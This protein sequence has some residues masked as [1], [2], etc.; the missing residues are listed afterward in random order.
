[1]LRKLNNFI[2]HNSLIG[3]VFFLVTPLRLYPKVMGS[4]LKNDFFRIHSPSS[5]VIGL[6]YRCQCQCVHCSASSYRKNLPDEL[7]Y[8]EIKILLNQIGKLGVPRINF[9]G[10]EALLREDIFEI[11]ECASKEFITV[12]ESNGQ[13]L[14][15]DNVRRLKN[16]NISCVAVSIDSYNAGVHDKLRGL[17]G[18]YSAAVKGILNCVKNRIPCLISTYVSSDRADS[19]NINGL[20]KLARELKVIAV[21]VMPARPVGSF[22]CQVSSLLNK[23]NESYIL[24]N[25][26]QS[27]AYFKGIPSPKYCGIFSRSTFYISPYGEIQPCPYMPLS[28][29]NV[30]KKELMQILDVMFAHPMFR[31]ENR[32]CLILDGNFRKNHIEKNFDNKTVFPIEI[33]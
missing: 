24:G 17:S 19:E 27:I 14:T 21:R 30:R 23:E 5:A 7:T 2:K 22:S 13:L 28:F 31:L 4:V 3:K 26:D 18:C 25:I 32:G 11:I 6:T 8:P 10:G 1:M 9:S 16:A 33:K 12:L 15:D 20:M 29:G